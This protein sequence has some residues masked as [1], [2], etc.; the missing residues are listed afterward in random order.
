[1]GGKPPMVL[2]DSWAAFCKD[3]GTEWFIPYSYIVNNQFYDWLNNC[4]EV[5]WGDSGNGITVWL[6]EDK[7]LLS[8]EF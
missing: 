3:E 7:L 2:R 6:C 8:K 5:D 1:M 4:D